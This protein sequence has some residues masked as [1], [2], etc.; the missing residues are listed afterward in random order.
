MTHFWRDD[1][2]GRSFG[3]T[4][5]VTD[6]GNVVPATLF[7]TTQRLTDDQL[8]EISC[9]RSVS[10]RPFRVQPGVSVDMTD[11]ALPFHN[12]S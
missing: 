3:V 1:E 12:G 5:G 4:S 7:S 10:K 8:S 2:L 9:P 11:L 6:P